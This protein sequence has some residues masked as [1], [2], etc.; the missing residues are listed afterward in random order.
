M[1]CPEN[2][3]SGRECIRTPGGP[4]RMV[5]S[6]VAVGVLG[7]LAFVVLDLNTRLD[8]QQR[9]NETSISASE[10]VVE[11]NDRLTSQLQQLTQLTQT[12]QRALDATAALGPLLSELDEAIAP[13][14]EML[15]TGTSGAQLTND[16]LAGIQSV[17]EEIQSVVLPLVSAAEAFGE[18]G[19]QLLD[20]VRRLVGDLTSSVAAARTINQML[21]L[22]G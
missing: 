10:G 9:V 7:L 8:N 13:A 1:T 4:A 6:I 11:V 17:L 19:T 21:P 12:A 18:Q 3:R 22:P 14:A 2:R 5:H 15:A 16:Q 20:I